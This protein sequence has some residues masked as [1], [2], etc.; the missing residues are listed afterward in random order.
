MSGNGQ[1]VMVEFSKFFSQLCCWYVVLQFSHLWN[2]W[3]FS[4][5]AFQ[6]LVRLLSEKLKCAKEF[7]LYLRQVAKQMAS[8]SFHSLP[9]EVKG[10]VSLRFGNILNLEFEPFQNTPW[11]WCLPQIAQLLPISGLFSSGPLLLRCC[12][13]DLPYL[14]KLNL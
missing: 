1:K 4:C 5:K 2:F 3:F 12:C 7:S 6:A 14:L 13:A 8:T 10:S 11:G 9:S